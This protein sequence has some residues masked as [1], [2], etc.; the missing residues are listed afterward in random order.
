[1][2]PNPIDF[3]TFIAFQGGHNSY[4]SDPSEAPVNY[5]RLSDYCMG[6]VTI[7]AMNFENFWRI[8]V[9]KFNLFGG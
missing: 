3:L 7:Q 5:I 8:S 6:F 2:Q 4:E 9:S 1:M